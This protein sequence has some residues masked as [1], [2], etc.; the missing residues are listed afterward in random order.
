MRLTSRSLGSS[1]LQAT[2]V[3]I[4]ATWLAP[5]KAQSA[6][7]GATPTAQVSGLPVF[8]VPAGASQASG[9]RA[10]LAPP[11]VNDVTRAYEFRTRLLGDP[12]CQHFAAE[13]DRIFL[14]HTLE[15]AQKIEQLKALGDQAQ[16]SGCLAP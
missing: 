1:L 15:D 8:G 4:L 10:P 14:D 12:Q 6:S 2:F 13:S 16:S 11:P 3:I 9:R 5:A 7:K